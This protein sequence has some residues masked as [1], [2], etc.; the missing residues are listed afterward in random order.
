MDE[1]VGAGVRLADLGDVPRADAGVHVA[2]AVPD[3]EATR[4]DQAERLGH[5]GA[6][7]HVR[8]EEDL[9]VRAVLAEDVLDDRRRRWTTSRSSR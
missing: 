1:E 7:E 4:A 6:Q 9:G 5:V 2:L 3:V 8:A